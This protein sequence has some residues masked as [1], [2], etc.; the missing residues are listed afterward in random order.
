MEALQSGYFRPINFSLYDFDDE[1]LVTFFCNDVRPIAVY[2]RS[3]S[4]A[5]KF[6]VMDIRQGK[7]LY[8]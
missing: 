7:P 1:T 4:G 2:A 5:M 8:G 6:A 3:R